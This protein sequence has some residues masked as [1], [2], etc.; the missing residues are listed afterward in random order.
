MRIHFVGI[1]GIGMSSLALHSRLIGEEVYGSD[2]YESEQTE[3]LRKLGVK[4]F[5][6]HNYNNWLDPDIVVH[7]PAVHS[8]NPEIIRAR[9]NGIRVVSRFEF[10][11]D[12]LNNG[13]TQFAVT[14]SDGKT[15]T[16]AMLAHCLKVLGEDPTV[17]LG[18]IHRSL[19]FGN[20]R[21]GKGPYVYEL[22]ESQPE[23]SRFSPD[24]MI[25]TNAR[26]DHLEN[27]SGDRQLYRDCFRS[28]VMSTRKSVVTF[29]EDEN[30]SDLGTWTFGK[31]INSTCRL[32]DRNRN[33]LFQFAKIEINGKEYN[34]TLKVPGEHNI[35]NAMAVITLLWSAGH[36]VEEVLK[37]LEDFTGTYRRFTV[38]VIDEKRKVYM[39]DDYAH[40]PDEIKSLLSTTREVFPSQKRVVIFQPHRYSRLMRE[41]GNFAKALKDADEIYITEVYSAFE[42]T[43]PQISSKV[44]ADGL[45]SYGKKAQYVAD[46]DL[47]IENFQL[48]ENTIYLFVGAGDIIRISQKFAKMHAKK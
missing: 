2:I 17:F 11:Y 41:D 32:I 14:G 12:I 47:L 28:V 46:A 33:G 1:G 3:I 5:I 45:V 44:I 35:L 40:T 8:D 15:T 26:G 43:I 21:P 18:G 6:G 19:E 23:F 30:T 27:Y 22:D 25:I 24:Y 42:Q 20:Y 4:I 38:T 13:K 9:S 7:T 36:E 39:I 48:Q 10:L 31:S 34:L 16:T 29:S 37:A